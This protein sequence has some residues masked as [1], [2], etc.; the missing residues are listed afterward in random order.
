MLLA[1]NI[2]QMSLGR[3]SLNVN[4]TWLIIWFPIWY[5]FMNSGLDL[6]LIAKTI[7]LDLVIGFGNTM[8]FDLDGRLLESLTD[9]DYLSIISRCAAELNYKFVSSTKFRSGKYTLDWW[10][11][12]LNCLTGFQQ[13]YL[14]KAAQPKAE[15]I[16]L[17]AHTGVD[18]LS[19]DGL[20]VWFDCKF[21]FASI[22]NFTCPEHISNIV[23]TY[24]LTY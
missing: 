15:T 10:E 16:G 8:E 9:W 1:Q 11:N 18:L 6:I 2:F 23:G 17:D 4:R 7:G 5:L 13:T 22:V 3:Y 24:S 21:E 12:Y 19:A 14:A 20:E